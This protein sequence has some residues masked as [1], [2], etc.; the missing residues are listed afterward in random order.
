MPSEK[1]AATL[2]YTGNFYTR[3]AGA[4]TTFGRSVILN[5]GKTDT[6]PYLSI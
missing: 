3:T 1:E 4:W 5:M 6:P 2:V